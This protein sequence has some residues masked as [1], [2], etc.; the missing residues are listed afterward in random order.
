[1]TSVVGNY[2]G[3]EDEKKAKIIFALALIYGLTI[4]IGLS[5]VTF[6]YSYEIAVTYT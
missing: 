3:M 2:I 5:L 4:T 6:I 1:M